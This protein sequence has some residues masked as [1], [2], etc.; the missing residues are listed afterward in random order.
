MKKQSRFVGSKGGEG[1]AQQIIS[2]MPRHRIYVE[3]FLG[4]GIVLRLKRPAELSFAI[5]LDAGTID[6]AASWHLRN[7]GLI[8][9]NALH[10]LPQL[11]QA[12]PER[13]ADAPLDRD[14]LVYAD[15]PYLMSARSSKRR[16]YREEFRSDE[17]HEQ[18][19]WL[20]RQ[21][22]CNVM[23][24]GYDSEL[25]RERLRDWRCESFPSSNRRGKTTEFLWM[26]FPAPAVLHDARFAGRNFIDRQRI[27]RKVARWT[28]KLAKLPAGERSA[29]KE[30]LSRVGAESGEPF[31]ADASIAAANGCRIPQEDRQLDLL[32]K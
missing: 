15:P 24:S 7:T 5:E 3:A 1:V 26:N 16:Y 8:Y 31:T 29:L 10:V 25:Y 9:G 20:L 28:G 6:S 17:Q 19:L 30:A 13:A 14:W 12:T 4:R 18:L 32:T 21:L 11:V 22:P 23:L 27:K 2:R